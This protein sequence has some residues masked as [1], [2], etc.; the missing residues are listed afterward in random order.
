M[1]IPLLLVV[2]STS[3]ELQPKTYVS[4]SGLWSLRVEPEERS[5]TG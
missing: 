5:G 1:L 4:P 3:P 2:L